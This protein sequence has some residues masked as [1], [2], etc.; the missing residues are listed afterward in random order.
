MGKKNLLFCVEQMAFW[1]TPD[2]RKDLFNLI[3]FYFFLRFL[4]HC[5]QDAVKE[6]LNEEAPL[7][8]IFEV[9]THTSGLHAVKMI[10]VS[11]VMLVMCPDTY[12]CY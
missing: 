8:D 6:S 5:C 3:F 2:S 1:A 12:L 11:N 7:I 9:Y 10:I 4:A